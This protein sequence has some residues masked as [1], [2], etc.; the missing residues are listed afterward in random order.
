MR[1][2]RAPRAVSVGSRQTASP[3]RPS[4]C[5]WAGR[6]LAAIF[7]PWLPRPGSEL[8][9]ASPCRPATS[10]HCRLSPSGVRRAEPSSGAP[11]STETHVGPLRL[12]RN[13]PM[14]RT[15]A[16]PAPVPPPAR[17]ADSDRRRTSASVILR[18]VLEHGPVARSTIARLTGLSPASVTDHCA[19]LHRTRPAP[20]GGRAPAV[21]RCGPPARP[22]RPGRLPVRGRRRAR[23]RAVHHGRA[24]RSARPGGGAA[25]AEAR[26]HR[27]RPGAGAGRRRARARCWPTPPA[28]DR[29]ASAWPSAAGWTGTP[30]PSSSI[31]CWAGGRCRCARCWAPAPGCRSM[32]TG[33]HGRWS[34]RS[35]CSGGR[36]AAAACCTCSSA[37]WSTRRSPPTTRCTTG[38]APRR[39]RSRICR[40]RAA[41]SRA[42]AAGSAASRPS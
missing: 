33:T 23:G 29:S 40:C 21:E 42:T 24:A 22:R 13:F 19:R 14:P 5:V 38:R 39:A 18:S 3:S 7:E 34:T 4:V 12:P 28:A 32:W 9:V 8:L 27:S 15:A 41:R 25:R 6:A 30:G 2:T 1:A 16:P 10:G 36:A 35:G 11:R 37:T 20:R 17:V 31:R 26:E